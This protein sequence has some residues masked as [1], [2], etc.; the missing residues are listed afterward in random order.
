[1]LRYILYIALLHGS[2][3]QLS[4]LMQHS[5]RCQDEIGTVFKVR[6]FAIG[7]SS[8]H[9]ANVNQATK[10]QLAPIQVR[11]QKLCTLE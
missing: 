7:F 11:L 6:Q 2:L 1:M 4:I 10:R 3:V 5:T 8:K 9:F